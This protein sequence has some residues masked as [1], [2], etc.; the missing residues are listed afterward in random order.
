[1][2]GQRRDQVIQWVKETICTHAQVLKNVSDSL[3]IL[4]PLAPKE[5]LEVEMSPSA[6]GF[7]LASSKLQDP[8][9]HTFE[10]QVTFSLVRAF[11]TLHTDEQQLLVD[12]SLTQASLDAVFQR[13]VAH[14]NEVDRA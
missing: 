1:M 11:Q 5:G 14:A 8:Q 10:E 7:S 2:T 12:F 9:D 3:Q 4:L 13:V 6:R